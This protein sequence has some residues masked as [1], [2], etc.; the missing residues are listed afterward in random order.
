MPEGRPL[1]PRIRMPRITRPGRASRAAEGETAATKPVTKPDQAPTPGNGT[2]PATEV[3]PTQGAA[4][5]EAPTK[6][7]PPTEAA[8]VATGPTT[9]AKPTELATATE[10]SLP[11]RIEGLQGWMADLERK[12]ARLTYFGG[13]ALLLALGVRAP[14]S[15]SVSPRTTT[16]PRRMTSARSP[17]ASTHC[18]ARS[19]R[20]ARTP[21][22][23]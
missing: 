7:T 21:R 13:L 6:E 9:S 20:T 18:R 19:A 14:P 15:T 12:Q 22:T 5:T 10:P 17:A 23:R 4:T 16:A 2:E 1:M 3:A 11:E 8:P